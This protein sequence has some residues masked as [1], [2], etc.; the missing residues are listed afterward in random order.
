MGTENDKHLKVVI[1][2]VGAVGS[3]FAYTLMISGLAQ[4]MVLIDRDRKRAEGEAMDLS[5]GLF[6][7]PPVD[8]RA[9]DY[10][11]CAGANIVVITAGATQKPGESRIGLT[12][13]NS[14]ICRSIL[15]R[16]LEHTRTAII[17]MVTNPVDVLT[18]DAIRYSGLPWR[19]VLGSGTVLDSARLRY[20][21]S[22]HCDLDAR[23]VHAY[24]LGEHG[25]SEVVAW[26]MTHVAGLR[27][28]QFCADCA[29][30]DPQ[31]HRTRLAR[32]VRDSAYHLIESKGFTNYGIGQAL[33]R[34]VGA[35]IRDEH[36]V[37]T[38]SSL[39]DGYLGITDVCLSVPCLV[40]REGIVRQLRPQLSEDEAER[41]RQSA[42][43]LKEVQDSVPA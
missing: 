8:I 1:V 7:A 4:E 43:K 24:V 29:R 36:S 20:L 34:I 28:A 30:C 42:A 21:L 25:D 14:S 2:G 41:L 17:V 40:G 33:L 38:V 6:F 27:M 18:Y 12:A 11:D 26:S 23:N 35:L 9:G 32:Q 37:L 19:Q 15:D 31:T 10:P 22:S 13:R 3:T 16:L 5:H 39:V